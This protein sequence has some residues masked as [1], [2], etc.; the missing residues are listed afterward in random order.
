M[1]GAAVVAGSAASEWGASAV[2]LAVV[3]FVVER[4]SLITA[5]AIAPPITTA[6]PAIAAMTTGPRRGFDCCPTGDCA[7]FACCRSATNDCNSPS[8]AAL[9]AA[10]TRCS[11][12]AIDSCP[13]A[14]A[15]S[16]TWQMSTRSLSLARVPGVRGVA[17]S[18]IVRVGRASSQSR[19]RTQTRG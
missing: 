15:L 10:F 14:S 9:V 19:C 13:S 8:V 7:E 18:K 11:C 16:R 4:E 5:Q 3:V 2:G 1:L 17:T 12:S 6:N